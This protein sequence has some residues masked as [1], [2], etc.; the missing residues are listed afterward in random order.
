MTALSG[1]KLFV[2]YGWNIAIMNEGKMKKDSDA[3]WKRK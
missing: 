3:E 2:V 1:E